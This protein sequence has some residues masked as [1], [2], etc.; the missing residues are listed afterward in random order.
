[1]RVVNSTI[2]IRIQYLSFRIRLE[3]IS[4]VYAFTVVANWSSKE[5][6]N[7]AIT[8]GAMDKLP[9]SF[10]RNIYAS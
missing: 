6:T 1:M 4:G 2:C 8:P 3:K 10:T 9:D 5:L 7:R